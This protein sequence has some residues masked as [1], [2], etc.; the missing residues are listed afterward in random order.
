MDDLKFGTRNKR[1]DWAPNEP[2]NVAPVFTFPP[3]PLKFLKWLPSYFAPYNLFFF[4]T[5]LI[6]WF[7]LLPDFSTMKSL[8]FGWMFYLYAV[9][10][11]GILL[12]FGAVELKLYVFRTQ[13]NRFKYNGNF[14]SDSKSDVFWFKS[15]NADNAIRTFFISIPIWTLTES[16]VMY[17]Y[18]NDYVPWVSFSENPAY[19]IAL[20]LAVP[21]IHE[22]HFFCIHW[23]IHQEPLYKWVHKI[24]HNSINP[25]PWSSMSMHPVEGSAYFAT[26]WYHLLIPSHPLIALYQLH[27]A[28]FGAIPGH[29]GFEKIEFGKS[30]SLDSHAYI[31][32]LHHKHFDVNYGDGLIPLDRWFGTFH[33]GSKEGEERM[34]ERFKKKKARMAAKQQS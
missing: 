14:P 34:L 2:A 21:V 11:L 28:G 19:V 18:A 7:Y 8:E 27:H 29:I 31:H 22:A 32:Y 26:A 33:D 4:A 1:G 17:V 5:A 12:F 9:N 13:G 25:T 30:H 23:L 10:A 24:H 6:Y 3:K 16:V 15:Q 20:V